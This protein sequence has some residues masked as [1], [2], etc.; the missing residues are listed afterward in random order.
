M[1]NRK[2]EIL[3]TDECASA[4]NRMFQLGGRKQKAA[5]K[6]RALI[7]AASLRE[8]PFAGLRV[9]KHGESRI[10]HCVK[11]DLNDFARLV[12]VQDQGLCLLLFVGDHEDADRWLENNKGLKLTRDRH[13]QW[14]S[15]RASRGL[16]Q[17]KD[18]IVGEPD[19]TNQILINRMP[20]E[21][22]N[23]FLDSI[24]SRLVPRLL[25][26]TAGVMPEDIL[27]LAKEI[28]NPDIA[29]LFFDV[30]TQLN[31]GDVDG[32]IARIDLKSGALTPVSELSPDEILEVI[33]GNSI[34]RI[35]T[36]SPDYQKYINAYLES[37]HYFGW[38]LFMHPEQQRQVDA[39]HGGSAKLSGVS[40][41]GKTCVAVKRAVRLA[42]SSSAAKVG[43]I[44]L[45]RSLATLIQRLVEFSCP[46]LV[47]RGR[48]KVISFFELCQEMLDEMEPGS[49]KLYHDVAWKAGDHIDEVFREYYRLENNNNDAACLLSLHRSL[50]AQSIDPESYI[51]EELDWIRSAVRPDQRS[52]YLD[53]ERAGRKIPIL[54][55]R[56]NAI[57]KGLEGWERK[58]RAVGVIDYLGLTTA[59]DKH[60]AQLKPR[61]TSVIVDE[62]QDFGTTELGIIRRLVSEGPNDLL[63]CG[64]LAQQILPKRQ[65]CK[66]AGIDII[67]ARSFSIRKNYRNSREILKAAYNV[68]M[69]NLDEAMVENSE[70]E[71]C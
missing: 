70:L 48:I 32:A 31:S 13:G 36:G 19:W 3:W 68:L 28:T 35:P 42:S 62:A 41:S 44:T 2:L 6:V 24:P 22:R 50:V 67:G 34:K 39:D 14:K 21:D 10:E 61:F 26:L 4:I 16:T 51:R 40:G 45:N 43:L 63:L 53:I 56:R 47:A 23:R 33:D 37:N 5:E 30:V 20:E 9:T 64:D 18:R 59:L 25:D 66:D 12:T 71:L 60:F 29:I 55:H 7:G 38:F 46:D 8:N 15:V 17:D 11:Y 52:S 69:E 27:R 58:M 65:S 1:S 54:P 57:L 49:V